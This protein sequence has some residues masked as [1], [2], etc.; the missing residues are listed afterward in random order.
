MAA[1]SAVHTQEPLKLHTRGD[2]LAQ[3]ATHQQPYARKRARAKRGSRIADVNACA[4]R[5]ELICTADDFGG[6]KLF[7][8]PCVVANADG[9]RYGGHSSHVTNCGF[10]QDGKWIVSTG[11]E[12]RGVFQWELVKE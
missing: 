4:R 11:G 12:D 5:G 1:C 10:T 7:R 6:V 8:Y 2:L 3:I 9:K